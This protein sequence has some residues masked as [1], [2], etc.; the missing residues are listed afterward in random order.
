MR[1]VQ[2][3]VSCLFLA[4]FLTFLSWQAVFASG[5]VIYSYDNHHR[6]VAAEY[7]NGLSVEY[8]YDL[9][10]N[11]VSQDTTTGNPVSQNTTSPTPHTA[12]IT[13]I[14]SGKVPLLFTFDGTSSTARL[15]RQPTQV[16][17]LLYPT[18]T[19]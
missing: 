17:A 3:S 14:T 5:E 7:S 8:G 13:S 11:L 18:G 9:T 1:L 4:L 16:S 6:L 2:R 19:P 12:N 10:S 15:A